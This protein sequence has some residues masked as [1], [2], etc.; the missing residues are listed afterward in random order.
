M[1]LPAI[2]IEG[3]DAAVRSLAG[4]LLGRGF[5]RGDVVALMAPNLPEYAIVFHGA[6]SVPG[7]PSTSR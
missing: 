2:A 5:A 4:G 3:L 7:F 1:T 6:V